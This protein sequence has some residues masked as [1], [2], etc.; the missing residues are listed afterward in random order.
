M[1]FAISAALIAF[2]FMGVAKC[3]V[4]VPVACGS[5]EANDYCRAALEKNFE[6]G[7]SNILAFTVD[8]EVNSFYA[9]TSGS[10]CSAVEKDIRQTTDECANCDVKTDL[11][12]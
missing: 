10:D 12:E 9:A 1:K 2:T 11:C 5:V 6:S 4:T 8:G 3:D 7:V